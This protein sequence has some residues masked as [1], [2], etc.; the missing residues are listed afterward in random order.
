VKIS[1]DERRRIIRFAYTNQRDSV[2][3]VPFDCQERLFRQYPAVGV[4]VFYLELS[5]LIE[6]K[7]RQN[8]Q[9]MDGLVRNFR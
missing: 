1:T 2:L 4:G 9:T 8:S 7:T 6:Q 5:R 3:Q